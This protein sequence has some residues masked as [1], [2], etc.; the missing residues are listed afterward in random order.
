[1]SYQDDRQNISHALFRVRMWNRSYR[2]TFSF[3]L[4]AAITFLG[5]V[6]GPTQML[7]RH[8]IA[9]TFRYGGLS[10]KVWIA[11]KNADKVTTKMVVDG[12][13]TEA[14]EPLH[15]QERR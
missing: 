13:E 12:V 2:L 7:E 9:D 10:L 1:M 14:Y 3:K 6:L 15:S 5:A 4:I 8:Q 11:D